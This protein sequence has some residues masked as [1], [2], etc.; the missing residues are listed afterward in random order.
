MPARSLQ[1]LL[2]I[3][4]T[5]F[6]FTHRVEYLHLGTKYPAVNSTYSNSALEAGRRIEP[7]KLQLTERIF[8]FFFYIPV[9][10]LF[11]S[12]SEPGGSRQQKR[13]LN[14]FHRSTSSVLSE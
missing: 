3:D 14:L 11:A 2:R 5:N 1:K 13:K 10:F 12:C 9:L 6:K 4:G 7:I 8:F